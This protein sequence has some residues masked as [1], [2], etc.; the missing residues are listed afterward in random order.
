MEDKEKP[1]ARTGP[2]LKIGLVAAALTFFM[3]LYHP[4]DLW[5][6]RQKYFCQKAENDA[7]QIVAAMADYFAVPAHKSITKA[8]IETNVSID[9]PWT[10]TKCGDNYYIHVFD[11]SGKCPAGKKKNAA[12]TRKASPIIE[13]YK[14]CGS[15]TWGNAPNWNAGVYTISLFEP[16]SN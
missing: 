1:K 10:L 14:K 13:Q 16:G 7:N 3:A 2:V 6:H 9:N 15:E 4:W 8:D 5:R 12:S 11:R